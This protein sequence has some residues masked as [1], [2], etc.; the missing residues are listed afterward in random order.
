MTSSK[1]QAGSNNH[2][3]VTAETNQ[4]R[5][6][7]DE[8]LKLD[9]V[10]KEEDIVDGVSNLSIIDE[11][12]VDNESSSN[13]KNQDL[14]KPDKGKTCRVEMSSDDEGISEA[15]SNLS[16]LEDTAENN[17][18]KNTSVSS[19][20]SG[21]LPSP[22]FHGKDA[23]KL[24]TRT[25]IA[26][27]YGKYKIKKKSTSN[28]IKQNDE[29]DVSSS[30]ETSI[31]DDSPLKERQTSKSNLNLPLSERIRLKS[32][33]SIKS[34]TSSCS[35]TS[36]SVSSPL[37][38][39][40][41]INLVSSSDDDEDVLLKQPNRYQPPQDQQQKISQKSETPSS[42]SESIIKDAMKQV[43]G[44][45]KSSK[46]AM[47]TASQGHQKSQYQSI[48]PKPSGLTSAAQHSLQLDMDRRTDLQR[49][50]GKLKV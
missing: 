47:P 28:L 31:I 40:E 18:D 33:E 35:S 34:S 37:C 41:V 48:Q 13:I 26:E 50:L 38:R 23:T 20:S 46:Q 15:M 24:F 14:D 12:D 10:E 44:Q 2:N 3:R 36:G 39:D 1:Q 16:T 49:Q 22:G 4:L 9:H 7:S 30:S 25:D 42:G 11:S 6:Q 43:Q 27:K 29:Q 21:S 32:N 8:G 5:N 45:I 17:G 19:S